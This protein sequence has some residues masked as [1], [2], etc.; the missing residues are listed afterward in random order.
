MPGTEGAEI[1][2]KSGEYGCCLELTHNH[3]TESDPNF[4]YHNGN[5]EPRGFGH[6]GEWQSAELV[7]ARECLWVGW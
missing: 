1:Y 7:C 6:I 4:K 5:E 2:L 3:G